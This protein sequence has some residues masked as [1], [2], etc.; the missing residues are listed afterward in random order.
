MFNKFSIFN[1]ATSFSLFARDPFGVQFSIRTAI[2]LLTLLSCENPTLNIDPAEELD[3]NVIVRVFQIESCT[4]LNYAIY[5]LD[6]ERVKQINQTSDMPTF[7]Q[8]AFQ[9]EED[10]YRLVVV[11]H[12]SG[13][14]PTM[15]DPTSI[16]FT[17]AQ[18]FTDTFMYSTEVTVTDEPADM[19]VTLD[20]ITSLCRFVLTDDDIP[21]DVKKLRFYYTGGSGAFDA[22]T[23]LGVVKSKQDVRF[24]VSATQRQFDLYTFLHNEEGTLHLTV[25]ALDASDNEITHRDFDVPMRQNQITW[26][27]GNF[28][29][30]SG[31][32]STLITGITINTDWA[33]ET[34][35]SF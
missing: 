16:R 3:G 7:G 21:S 24:E 27:R 25:T 20:R 1:F 34:Y 9:L 6:G 32:S 15:K 31:S 4:R 23:G 5:T 8:C 22:R 13:G 19:Q 2:A 33:G 14:N 26:L 35:I 17:N 18:G 28:F 11:G 12:S 30:G 10:D 29:N